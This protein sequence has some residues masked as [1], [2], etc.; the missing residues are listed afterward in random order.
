M[1]RNGRRSCIGSQ[2]IVTGTGPVHAPVC[3]HAQPHLAARTATT[4]LGMGGVLT[5]IALV[6][7]LIIAVVAVTARR[8]RNRPH[9]GRPTTR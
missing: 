7:V 3:G 6:A 2:F 4:G 9:D 1:K 8:I 5:T